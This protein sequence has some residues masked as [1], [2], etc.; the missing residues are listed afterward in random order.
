MQTTMELRFPPHS[1]RVLVG[2]ESQLYVELRSTGSTSREKEL[3]AEVGGTKELQ[4]CRSDL[5]DLS[6]ISAAI[7]AVFFYAW[8]RDEFLQ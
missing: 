3:P 2:R 8:R 1:L 6:S 4:K 5:K 7:R